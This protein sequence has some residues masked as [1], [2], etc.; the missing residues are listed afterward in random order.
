METQHN[1]SGIR[2]TEVR[3]RNFRSLK[4]VDVKLDRLTVLVGANNS[5]K[6]SFLEA[7]HAAIGAGRQTLG[8]EDT[9]GAGTVSAKQYK[10]DG[11]SFYG[12]QTGY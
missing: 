6:T 1:E 7:L 9:T 11:A 8:K 5:G 2:I 3:V 10:T 4:S 12:C